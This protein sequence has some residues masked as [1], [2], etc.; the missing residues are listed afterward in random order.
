MGHCLNVYGIDDDQSKHCLAFI[1][2]KL[3][4]HDKIKPT[5]FEAGV[6][7]GSK[8]TVDVK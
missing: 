1:Y 5:I 3:F 7:A 4:L 8:I 2:I 6:R